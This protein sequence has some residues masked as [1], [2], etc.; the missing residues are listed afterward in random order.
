MGKLPNPV[1]GTRYSHTNNRQV[2]MDMI[3][4]NLLQYSHGA[5][6]LSA[7]VEIPGSQLSNGRLLF[8]NPLHSNA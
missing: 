2:E 6:V 4:W 3:Q 1:L 5:V 8:K 7:C